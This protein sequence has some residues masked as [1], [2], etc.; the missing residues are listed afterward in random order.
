MHGSRI[1]LRDFNQQMLEMGER[2][3]ALAEGEGS[4]WRALAEG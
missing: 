3:L 1:Y 2:G 4:R